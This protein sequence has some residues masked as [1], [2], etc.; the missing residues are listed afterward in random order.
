MHTEQK[1]VENVYKIAFRRS[2]EFTQ[3]FSH[4]R[5]VG[6]EGFFRGFV[7]NNYN[8]FRRNSYGQT[9]VKLKQFG[10]YPVLVQSLQG[11]SGRDRMTKT[12]PT[13]VHNL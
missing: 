11:K 3:Y 12:F 13:Q 6:S 8:Y 4:F 5:K 2:N 1:V 7:T 10:K 9:R